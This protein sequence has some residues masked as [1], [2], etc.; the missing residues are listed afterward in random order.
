MSHFRIAASTDVAYI[1]VEKI[2]H[3]GKITQFWNFQKYHN[4]PKIP[5]NLMIRN[6][7]GVVV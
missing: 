7:S 3:F 5:K 2:T 1:M 4:S 6:Y